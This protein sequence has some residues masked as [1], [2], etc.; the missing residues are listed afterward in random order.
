MLFFDF[1]SS[2]LTAIF[3]LVSCRSFGF[4]A[5]LTDMR[6]CCCM[7]WP[8][9]LPSYLLHLRV[10]YFFLVFCWEAYLFFVFS[11]NHRNVIASWAGGFYRVGSSKVCQ[12]VSLSWS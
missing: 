3:F 7:S 6:D 8:A 9:H 10:F 2:E 12:S 11:L 5:V 1:S 4:L